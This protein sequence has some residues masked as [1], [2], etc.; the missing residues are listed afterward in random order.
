MPQVH[1]NYRP[2]D[3]VRDRQTDV[4]YVIQAT[5]FVAVGGYF[6]YHLVSVFDDQWRR[7]IAE[8]SIQFG[9]RFMPVIENVK[10]RDPNSVLLDLRNQMSEFMQHDKDLVSKLADPENVHLRDLLYLSGEASESTFHKGV[11]QLAHDLV[12]ASGGRPSKHTIRQIIQETAHGSSLSQEMIDSLVDRAHKAMVSTSKS[13]G[14][15]AVSTTT[16]ADI[17]RMISSG[18]LK[19]LSGMGMLGDVEGRFA[20]LKPYERQLV[21]DVFNPSS[22][23]SQ[24]LKG[25]PF[26]EA[27]DA[28]Q[29]K[30]ER[31]SLVISEWMRAHNGQASSLPFQQLVQRQTKRAARMAAHG[32]THPLAQMVLIGAGLREAEEGIVMRDRTG[33]VDDAFG[34]L[35]R[36][37]QKDM[38]AFESGR[39]WGK[40][41][42]L[43][44]TRPRI[45]MYAR[46]KDLSMMRNAVDWGAVL[47][48]LNSGAGRNKR[49]VRL[50]S[51][52]KSTLFNDLL[53]NKRV[54]LD[55]GS[56]WLNMRDKGVSQQVSEALGFAMGERATHSTQS[57][58][59]NTQSLRQLIHNRHT[60][61]LDLTGLVHESNYYQTL[62][63]ER[64]RAQVRAV[65]YPLRNNMSGQF[66][67]N[68]DPVAE[69]WAATQ[70][71]VLPNVN[72]PARAMEILQGQDHAVSKILQ[73]TGLDRQ[74]EQGL[75]RVF[76]AK[77]H[78]Q[79]E[80]QTY[81]AEHLH[82]LFH[83]L[84]TSGMSLTPKD[85]QL[86]YKDVSISVLERLRKNKINDRVFVSDILSGRGES[87]VGTPVLDS[88]ALLARAHKTNMA[89]PQA[90]VQALAQA[91]IAPGASGRVRAMLIQPQRASRP[92]PVSEL[93]NMMANQRVAVAVLKRSVDNQQEVKIVGTNL[94]ETTVEQQLDL[95]HMFLTQH[96]DRL[97][98]DIE[99]RRLRDGQWTTKQIS[100]GAQADLKQISN[101]WTKNSQERAQAIVRFA[102]AA[103]KVSVVASQ[104]SFDP[105]QLITEARSLLN[106]PEVKAVTKANLQQAVTTLEASV[107]TKWL[108][109]SFMNSLRT[110]ERASATNQS[111]LSLKYLRDANGVPVYERHTSHYDVLHAL[112]LTN[113]HAEDLMENVRQL[114]EGGLTRGGQAAQGQMFLG[115]QPMNAKYGQV[116]GLEGVHEAVGPTG[117]NQVYAHYRA[118]TPVR[119]GQGVHFLPETH[120]WVERHE[121][122]NALAAGMGHD[123]ALV[124]ADTWGAFHALYEKGQIDLAERE[125]RD[126]LNPF[127]K[128]PMDET[129]LYSSNLGAQLGPLSEVKYAARMQARQ[130]YPELE[131]RMQ[132]AVDV[133]AATEHI[134]A[135]FGIGGL[136][137]MMKPFVKHELLRMHDS[138]LYR[139]RFMNPEVSPMAAM[140]DSPVG[141][142]LYG[143]IESQQQG[144][145]A[146]VPALFAMHARDHMWQNGHVEQQ[147]MGARLSVR[148][149]YTSMS[150]KYEQG[151]RMLPSVERA[152]AH[153]ADLAAEILLESTRDAGREKQP[154]M[155][156]MRRAGMSQTQIDEVVKG[157]NLLRTNR[158]TDDHSTEE[159]KKL[160][161]DTVFA[162]DHAST[163]DVR[164]A[165]RTLL[166]SEQGLYQQ[167][168]DSLIERQQALLE[169][170][171]RAGTV[172][173]AHRIGQV[174]RHMD[175]L[176]AGGLTNVADVHRVAMAH[177]ANTHGVE[178]LDDW[179]RTES[180]QGL[181]SASEETA[182]MWLTQA[183]HMAHQLG[184][185]S[186]RDV[187]DLGQDMYTALTKAKTEGLHGSQAQS[188]AMELLREA[189]TSAAEHAQAMA[190]QGMTAA[191]NP[192]KGVE[193]T[194]MARTMNEVGGNF[195]MGQRVMQDAQQ[196]MV[197]LSGQAM[198]TY[199][200]LRM[201]LLLIGGAL[202]MMAART[203]TRDAFSQ[204]KL[205]DS[206]NAWAPYSARY[207]EIPG[208]NRLHR[209]WDA[210]P[211][212]FRLDITFSG[213]VKDKIHQEQLVRH[214]YDAANMHMDVRSTS[215][216]VEDERRGHHRR[217]ARELLR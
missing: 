209:T 85:V 126:A 76:L 71:G 125:V 29:D 193:K 199:A 90:I 65:H 2:G 69:I 154:H 123:D 111:Y 135:G 95:T 107:K 200:D 11:Q 78:G 45:S 121:S 210:D 215:T 57:L 182:Q 127:A 205:S 38:K 129:M 169:S 194:I 157:V 150:L 72:G 40:F 186:D 82:D 212:P 5:A 190:E 16:Q 79:A 110:G 158:G 68:G 119:Q 128:R 118:Y 15:R 51:L 164:G 42:F 120:T 75:H 188:R 98:V 214:V 34:W 97:V 1:A 176:R 30:M 54:T 12:S 3:V 7:E 24:L 206:Q 6:L 137:P 60:D 117:A 191:G 53:R 159:W 204:G 94:L 112:Q 155:D 149:G 41:H 197:L 81:A 115:T 58:L 59:L 148:A 32:R 124:S 202:G 192:Q 170:T 122:V 21:N 213:F 70:R 92:V 160:I 100:W 50:H 63:D 144:R 49:L 165:M 156:I 208:T 114:R 151:G 77:I 87:H 28:Q 163:N 10:R 39:P 131:H 138:P 142:A 146:L 88:E 48:N 173:A 211:Q 132:S 195:G 152:S 106:D 17:R 4:D 91:R 46:D 101:V 22:T 84:Q 167:L 184:A 172:E 141:Q 43:Q 171:E 33:V 64:A 203:P 37:S 104:G 183:Q 143:A 93:Q 113:V 83:H 8:N 14:H 44:G 55:G 161:Q 99:T 103:D 36:Y 109:L 180:I 96:T 61:A 187:E 67:A 66:L 80:Q 89:D 140:M 134:M 31:I 175:D 102:Q 145:G 9:S 13:M 166:N 47:D 62:L 168:K 74:P 35:R 19:V 116:Y 207:A 26:W 181:T 52:D 162:G 18:E 56:T 189:T 73:F 174:V 179:T 198:K 136:D 217:A 108:D 196:E 23:M 105:Y 147:N 133:H 153:F 86:H 139:E 177:A 20:N 185:T 216:Q 178:F 130:L 25:H 27:V 201:P